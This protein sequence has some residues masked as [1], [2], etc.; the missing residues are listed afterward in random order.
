MS[1][2]AA[3]VGNL[4]VLKYPCIKLLNSPGGGAL[5]G[6]KTITVLPM[7]VVKSKNPYTVCVTKLDGTCVAC[8]AA[9]VQQ[10]ALPSTVFARAEKVEERQSE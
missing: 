5:C 7:V 8:S 9:A 10:H 4:L 1:S 3:N 2:M 6:E